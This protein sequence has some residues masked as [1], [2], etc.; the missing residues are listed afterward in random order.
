MVSHILLTLESVT[1]N[2]RSVFE[3][4][5]FRI[6]A[7][8]ISAMVLISGIGAGTIPVLIVF[9]TGELLDRVLFYTDFEPLT[10][11]NTIK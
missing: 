1:G 4:R 7:L 6:A 8:F 10:I 5:F 3:V 9:L 2:K 11:N